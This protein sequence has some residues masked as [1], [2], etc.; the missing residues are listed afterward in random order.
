MTAITSAAAPRRADAVAAHDET[1]ALLARH[2]PPSD[3]RVALSRIADHVDRDGVDAHPRPSIDAT[4]GASCGCGP[5][6]TGSATCTPRCR[7]WTA[8][9]ARRPGDPGPAGHHGRSPAQRRADAFTLPPWLRPLLDLVHAHCRGPDCDRRI[10]WTQAHHQHAWVQLGDTDVNQ[11][12]RCASGTTTSSPPVGGTCG[13]TPTRAPSPGPAPA[14]P[15]IACDHRHSLTRGAAEQS[16]LGG[17]VDRL[18]GAR[19]QVARAALLIAWDTS[20]GAST[21]RPRFGSPP[22]AAFAPR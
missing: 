10:P 1:L 16:S 19:A 20:R 5:A 8:H 21:V 15:S 4:R 17:R 3:L 7:S 9:A 18:A 2:A 14:A 12:I 11:T 22:R 6:S 13:S